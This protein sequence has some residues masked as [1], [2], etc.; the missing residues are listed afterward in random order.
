M[1]VHVVP[2]EFR[3]LLD[4]VLQTYDYDA[5]LLTLA[6]GDADP[7]PDMNVW[8]SS[9]G[10]HLWHPAQKVPATPWEAEI[11]RLMRQ[12]MVTSKY[13]ERKRLFDRVQE[14]LM[15][16]L[17]LIPLVSPDILV[18]ARNGLGNFRPALLDHYTLWNIEELYWR[19]AAG[20]RR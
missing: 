5:C 14:I 15:E 2:L 4:R 13:A 8:L 3:S 9:G 18:G 7:N 10:N 20:T 12:Q 6:A 1:D 17:P 11:D 16:N 19:S